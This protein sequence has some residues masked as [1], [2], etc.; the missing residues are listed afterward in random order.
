MLLYVLINLRNEKKNYKIKDFYYILSV[1]VVN[2]FFV[3]CE[4]NSINI[5]ASGGFSTRDPHSIDSL[6]ET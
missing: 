2:S 1:T 3:E 4:R 5:T 6:P